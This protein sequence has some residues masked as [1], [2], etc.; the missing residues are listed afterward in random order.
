[1]SST[2]NCLHVKTLLAFFLEFA[3][4]LKFRDAAP[5]RVTH[6]TGNRFPIILNCSRSG[7]ATN[8][9]RRTQSGFLVSISLVESTGNGQERRILKRTAISFRFGTS[10]ASSHTGPKRR[11]R[12]KGEKSLLGRRNKTYAAG[13]TSRAG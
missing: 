4:H 12:I 10:K 3:A 6:G 8:I 13:L 1:V 5:K 9:F 2:F 11:G 7:E